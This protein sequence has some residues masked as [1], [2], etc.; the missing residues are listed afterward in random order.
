MREQV[1]TKHGISSLTKSAALQYAQ[2]EIRV[3]AVAPGLIRT[4]LT[5]QMLARSPT[6]SP[7]CWRAFLKVAGVTQ[8]RSRKRSSFCVRLA[9]LI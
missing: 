3:N 8:K 1:G 9:A 5:K 2:Q 7:R 6:P 4:A